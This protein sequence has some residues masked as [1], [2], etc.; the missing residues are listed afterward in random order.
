MVNSG[1]LGRPPSDKRALR[2]KLSIPRSAL[3]AISGALE[4]PPGAVA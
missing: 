2:R 4:P 1:L 3:A